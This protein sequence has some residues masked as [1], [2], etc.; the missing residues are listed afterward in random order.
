MTRED[1]I[2]ECRG[3]NLPTDGLL[4]PSLYSKLRKE[5]KGI[6]WVPALCF[7]NQTTYLQDLNLAQYEVVPV[8]PLHDLKEHINN[9][10]KELPKHLTNKEKVLFEKARRVVLLIS[11]QRLESLPHIFLTSQT[12][13]FLKS[14]LKM[15]CTRHTLSRLVIFFFV[16]KEYGG[17]Q[18]KRALD[19]PWALDDH[20]N[21]E[22][23][24]DSL[25]CPDYTNDTQE[26]VDQESLNQ[27]SIC[28]NLVIISNIE[29]AELS[30]NE[31]DEVH[32]DA[33]GCGDEGADVDSYGHCDSGGVENTDVIHSHEANLHQ[34]EDHSKKKNR[35]K[36]SWG[37]HRLGNKY[38]GNQACHICFKIIG[39]DT[40]CKYPRQ[41]QESPSQEGKLS[42]K[43]LSK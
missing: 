39:S 12:L 18:M 8:E 4:K 1:L 16:E 32:V 40:S 15:K 10:L 34:V 35:S 37:W 43:I 25:Q 2:K 29:A 20:R 14:Y 41:G 6:Q 11:S 28:N 26:S 30:D 22:E 38:I 27:E 5:L 42:K 7:P 21:D 24:N 23:H 3:C 36:Q 31:C 13:S 17:T 33:G 19:D 9:L